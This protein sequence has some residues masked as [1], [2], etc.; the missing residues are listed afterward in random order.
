MRRRST[1][2]LASVL[3]VAT[4]ALA[5]AQQIAPRQETST[6]RPV[7]GTAASIA[8]GAE[9]I[10]AWLED[11]GARRRVVARA[12]AIGPYEILGPE[13]AGFDG[14]PTTAA[15]DDGSAWVLASRSA[16]NTQ[17]LWLQRRIGGRWQPA[18]S[19]PRARP[20]DHHPAMAAGAGEE[21]W[22]VWLGED[23]ANP[24]ATSL[25]ASRWDGSSWSGA[26]ALPRTVGGPMAPSLAVDGAGAPV[27]AWAASDGTDA[28]IWISTRTGGRWSAPRSLSRNQVPDIMP[29][30]ARTPDGLLATWISYTDDGYLPVARTSTDSSSW[31]DIQTLSATS[32]GRVRAA[33]V[34]GQPAVFWRRLEFS[35][36]GGTITSRSLGRDGWNAAV[37]IAAVSGS[38]FAV[39]TARDGSVSLAFSRPDGRLGVVENSRGAGNE[40]VSLAAAARTVSP[41]LP[42]AIRA[43]AADGDPDP[44][45]P[46]PSIYTAFGDSIT[47]GVVYNPERSDSAGYRD[48]L[49]DMLRAFFRVGSVF[50]AGVDGESTADG[51]G[52]IDNAIRAH[53]PQAI[54]IMEG[55]NDILHAVDVET[56]A[57]NLR[58]MVQ[59]SFEERS[60]ILPFLAQ[61][62]PRLDP[63]EE[64]F[65]GPGNGRIDE[66]NE[67]LPE[68]ALQEG[69]FIVDQNT[70]FD[71]HPELMSNPLHP[72]EIGYE[73]MAETWF[74]AIQPA[75]LAETNMGDVDGSGRTDGLDLVR[76]ALA[77]GALLGEDRYDAAADI[78]GDGLIDGF[79]LDLLIEFFGQEV[80]ATAEGGS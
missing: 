22:A 43:P 21:L 69:A 6:G 7:V 35:P 18:T 75:V 80:G 11:S 47:N 34:D 62:P 76:L 64:G 37:D 68:I 12:S 77:F 27:V 45:P 36:A 70:P 40:L 30:I 71:G 23:Q 32:G 74:A 25:F 44:E 73:V 9:T 51:V 79:D 59:R 20:F 53:D 5:T 28:E 49:Q 8:H 72:S 58:R 31:N 66:L 61:I 56:T 24:S 46:V 63:G 29:S 67:M 10:V 3:L 4:P 54:L 52:R 78:N 50:N 60:T 1:L 38:P 55:T 16:N 14:A 39:G 17:T 2:V 19:G 42:D 48:P 26:E 41:P 65:D 13:T 15:T 57:F 33:V